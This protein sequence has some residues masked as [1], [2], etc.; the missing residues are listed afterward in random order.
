MARKEER[1][2]LPRKHQLEEAGAA[3]QE[4]RVLVENT[5]RILPTIDQSKLSAND[6]AM[7]LSLRM[8]AERY[9][10]KYWKGV[11]DG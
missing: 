8:D 4:F 5:A 11:S 7:L 6:R 2:E 1:I 9:N 3:L 10:A